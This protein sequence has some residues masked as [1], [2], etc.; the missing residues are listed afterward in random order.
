TAITIGAGGEGNKN[1][2]DWLG[3]VPN[4]KLPIRQES[5]KIGQEQVQDTQKS[6]PMNKLG[7]KL[8]SIFDNEKSVHSAM[9]FLKGN[10]RYILAVAF[11]PNGKLVASGSGDRTVRLRDPATGQ[12]RG[13]LKGHSDW[14]WSVT[15]SPDGKLVA[16][17]SGDR[18][19]RL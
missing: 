2:A 5:V 6:S 12:G 18:T 1:E 9:D 8:L 13:T 7:M 10:C 14:V 15:F 19:V 11:S 4:P 17:G 3:S 16:S